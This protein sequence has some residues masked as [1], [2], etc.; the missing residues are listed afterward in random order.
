MPPCASLAAKPEENGFWGGHTSAISTLTD[1]VAVGD[2]EESW[3]AT[4]GQ[5]GRYHQLKRGV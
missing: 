1:D 3:L 2:D 5:L 4:A